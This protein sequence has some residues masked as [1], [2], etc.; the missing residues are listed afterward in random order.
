ME[1]VSS[2]SDNIPLTAACTLSDE[3]LPARESVTKPASKHNADGPE[4]PPLKRRNSLPDMSSAICELHAGI[5]GTYTP[6][7][8]ARLARAVTQAVEDRLSDK[9]NPL[10]DVW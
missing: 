5:E 6:G 9:I 2:G 4:N 7:L 1:R 3:S 8:K 10:L